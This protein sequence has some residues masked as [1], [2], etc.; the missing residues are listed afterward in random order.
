MAKSRI[1]LIFGEPDSGKSYLANE[2]G[3]KYGYD[4]ISLDEAY[5]SFIK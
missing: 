4:V 3:S 1:I 5:V 2:L